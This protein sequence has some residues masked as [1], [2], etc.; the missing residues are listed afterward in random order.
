MPAGLNARRTVHAGFCSPGCGAVA[1]LHASSALRREV[2][3]QLR[4]VVEGRATVD[5]ALPSPTA[6]AFDRMAMEIGASPCGNWSGC[7]AVQWE[8][9]APE[10]G[11]LAVGDQFQKHSYPFA[12]LINAAG[13]RFVDEGADFRNYTYAKYG[14]V[15]LEQPGQFEVSS[16][17]KML[18]QL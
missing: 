1:A 7:H 10:F 18:E 14:R 5:P 2:A 15:V 8:M 6:A 17:E 4:E 13:R 3:K 16:A 9:N 12:I 11:D